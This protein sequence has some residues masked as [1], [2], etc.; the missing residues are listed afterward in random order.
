MAKYLDK[1][2][3]TTLWGKIL[4]ILPTVS[5]GTDI[6]V[7]TTTVN[8][9]TNYQVSLGSGVKTAY[10]GQTTLSAGTNKDLSA[11]DVTISLGGNG[12]SSTTKSVTLSK[13]NIPAADTYEFGSD[14]T[15]A[16]DG[17]TNN[18]K[19]T[20]SLNKKTGGTGSAVK[21][22]DV[23]LTLNATDFL[24]DGI[25]NEAKLCEKAADLPS[26]VTYTGEYPALAFTFIE[27]VTGQKNALVFSVKSLVDV[28]TTG[29]GLKVNSSDSHKFEVKVN[30]SGYLTVDSNGVD[31]LSSK[32]QAATATSTY[33]NTRL[34][35]AAYVDEKAKAT[36]DSAKAA[37][38]GGNHTNNFVKVTIAATTAAPTVQTTVTA[39]PSGQTNSALATK[40]YVDQ[41]E[42]S[43]L[44]NT[45]IDEAI[46]A[47]T[48]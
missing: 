8:G 10:Q 12:A 30:S 42:T 41:F 18:Y 6:S 22:D 31:I 47:A 39:A 28:Y 43:A 13:I 32:I 25:L 9:H 5:Q 29:N 1:A 3:L 14:A 20:I 11:G 34:A 26:G 46:A 35:T 40:E 37:V 16:K 48:A 36:L 7:T 45:E 2:G 23:E 19:V 4:A 44:T 33:T 38:T 27:G 21:V 15:F 24:K 17:T